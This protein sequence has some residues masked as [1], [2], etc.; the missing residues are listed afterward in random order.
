MIIFYISMQY[1]ISYN[2][3]IKLI[4]LSFYDMIKQLFISEVFNE[5]DKEVDL[6]ASVL[7]GFSI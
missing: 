3:T 6:A 7:P 5:R 1:S 2:D 4:F